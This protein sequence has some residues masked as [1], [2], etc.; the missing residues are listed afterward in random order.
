MF[1]VVKSTNDTTILERPY[2]GGRLEQCDT[3]GP[4]PENRPAVPA[5]LDR[6]IR[7]EAGHRCA[8]PTCRSTAAPELAHIIPWADVREHRFDN[9]ILLC[10]NDHHSFDS[11]K[12]SHISMKNYKAN[13]SILNGRYS[14]T[15]RRLLEWFADYGPDKG[16]LLEGGGFLALSM[17]NLVRDGLVTS[18]GTKGMHMTT[19]LV[20]E[21]GRHL[22]MSASSLPTLFELTKEGKEF[23]EQWLSAEHLE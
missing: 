19:S 15:E 22:G 11:G 9:M 6:A 16:I 23:V 10:A 1:P 5:A 14:D 8:I 18:I 3:L 13:L 17:R 20:T 4:M 2:P 7:E 12:I 21:D